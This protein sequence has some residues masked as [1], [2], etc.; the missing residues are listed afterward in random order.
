MVGGSHS[1]G[2]T[3]SGCTRRSTRSGRALELGR[4]ACFCLSHAYNIRICY[5]TPSA[6]MYYSAA[7]FDRMFPRSRPTRSTRNSKQHQQKSHWAYRLGV[8]SSF[9]LPLQFPS[10]VSFWH[11]RGW[12]TE[13]RIWIWWLLLVF[14]EFFFLS[15][16]CFALPG[17]FGKTWDGSPK[18][19]IE[20]V[21]KKEKRIG[22][23]IDIS[24]ASLP[25]VFLLFLFLLFS[26]FHSRA[27][28][29]LDSFFSPMSVVHILKT[30]TNRGRRRY[31]SGQ[32]GSGLA[33]ERKEDR[34]YPHPR[35]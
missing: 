29:S 10:F 16:L 17:A 30:L 21:G 31:C 26:V 8:F 34:R 23:H 22:M 13:K 28:F 33:P 4:S 32:A 12:D 19:E 20:T 11:D 15:L 24:P 14:L 25:L 6:K 2:V 1:G 9:F 3:F 7:K 35:I 5:N 18:W 27:V